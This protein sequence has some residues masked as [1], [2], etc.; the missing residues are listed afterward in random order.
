MAILEYMREG[1]LSEMGS[2]DINVTP[3][4]FR[5]N[6]DGRYKFSAKFV[7][8]NGKDVYVP[9]SVNI[10][11]SC[12]S[13]I[14]NVSFAEVGDDDYSTTDIGTSPGEKL[15]VLD[16]KMTGVVYCIKHYLS[17][18]PCEIDTI[19][20]SPVRD[21]KD[22][23]MNKNRRATTYIYYA[24]KFLP[25]FMAITRNDI[26]VSEMGNDIALKFPPVQ[27]KETLGA[28]IKNTISP[29]V[30]KI[31]RSAPSID[32]DSVVADKDGDIPE[33]NYR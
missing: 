30:N 31:K 3:P 11:T 28:K 19:L 14:I 20:F 33:F 15:K 12:E 17:D 18:V 1:L 25:Q 2:G 23:Q 21:E 32:K 22:V 7:N 27:P 10:D 13:G 4:K 16:S 9:M 8:D 26:K 24:K 29:I 5:G 6:S